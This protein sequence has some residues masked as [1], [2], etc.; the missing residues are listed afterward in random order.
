MVDI[1]LID[2]ELLVLQALQ[3]VLQEDP[4]VNTVNI[5]DSANHFLNSLSVSRLSSNTIIISEI[6]TKDTSGIKLIQELKHYKSSIKI[7]ILS[8]IYETKTVR[9]AMK[10]GAD[11]YLTKN[12]SISEFMKAIKSV[13]QGQNYISSHLRNQLVKTALVEEKISFSLSPREREVLQHICSGKTIKEAA[14]MMGLS[15]NTVQSYHKSVLK[16]LN[17]R[18]TSD[19][20]V[21]ALQSGL[22]V[23]E[24]N[25]STN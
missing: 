6:I 17:I 9:Y 1:V 14:G 21:F 7:I 20:I 15:N 25:A 19:L 13:Y 5:Y 16:K 18:R 12:I 23:P 4:F 3:S 11:G 8:G 22:I 24:I 10:L 2:K